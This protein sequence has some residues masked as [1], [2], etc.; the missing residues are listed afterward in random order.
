MPV[1]RQLMLK[2]L[3]GGALVASDFSICEAPSLPSKA[4]LLAP[5]FISVD[6]Y[7]RTRMQ[8]EGYGYIERW[9]AGSVMSGWTLAEVVDSR[10]PDWR[11][12]DWAVGHL[13]M[14]D[15]IAHDGVGLWH[16]A[17]VLPAPLELM[18]PMG[19][20]GFTAWVGMLH[21]GQL[22]CGDTVLVSAAAGAVGSIAAQ[23]AKNSGARVVVTAGRQDKR[24]WL[25]SIGFTEVLDHYA[26]DFEMMLRNALPGGITLNFENIGG[27]VFHAAN[28]L[29]RENGRVVL[30]GLVSQ[31]QENNPRQA[32]SNLAELTRRK[33]SVMPFTIPSYQKYLSAF[34]KDMKVRLDAGSLEWR[35]NIMQGGLDAVPEALIGV[36]AGDNIGK[37]LVA[38]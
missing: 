2:K 9:K 35:L 36:L 21:V 23:L 16:R 5:K 1:N 26:S 30:C 18:H 10:H 25:R 15:S 11:A 6:P 19:M 27:R 13:P 32:P 8:Q 20:T 7:M 24:D 3:P 12:G 17:G 4:L 34:H 31:Y 14:Q 22:V 33:V 38:C 28:E 37:R 29:M